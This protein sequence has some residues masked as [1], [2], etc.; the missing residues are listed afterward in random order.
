ML[1]V[2]SHGFSIEFSVFERYFARQTDVQFVMLFK[3][4]C[5]ILA[6]LLSVDVS[7]VILARADPTDAKQK[8]GDIE[9]FFKNV[10]NVRFI[11]QKRRLI[12]HLKFRKFILPYVVQSAARGPKSSCS[13]GTERCVSLTR[14]SM[15]INRMGCAGRVD[16]LFMFL[17]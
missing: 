14:A 8:G 3:F 1:T 12:F 10:L 9:I 2:L 11:L 5:F 17:D 15:S 13:H 16:Q 7:M 4:F 6:M